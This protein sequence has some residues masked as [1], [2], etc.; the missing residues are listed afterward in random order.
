MSCSH[1]ELREDFF[2][3]NKRMLLIALRAAREQEGQ[4]NVLGKAA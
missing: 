3:L 4:Q 1:Y 2:F